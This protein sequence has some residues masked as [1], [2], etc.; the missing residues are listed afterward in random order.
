[1]ENEQ[2][3]SRNPKAELKNTTKKRW[4]KPLLV[5]IA[6]ILLVGGFFAW[7]TGSLFDKISTNGNLL[8]SLSRMVPGVTEELVGEKEGRVNILLLGMRG[9]ELTGGGLLA[10]T[11]MVASIAPTENKISLF[12]VPRDLYVQNPGTD[13]R[14]KINAVYAYGEEKRK[15]GGMEDMKTVVS[16]IVGQ[17]IGYALAINFKGFTDLVNAID[18]VEVDLK[19]PFEESMQFNEERACDAYTFTKPTGRFENKYYTRSEGTK[20]LAK[21]YPLC[22]NPNVE[23]GG[24]FKL[25]AGKQTLNG[26]QALCYARSR[27]TTSDFERAKRQQIVIQKIKDKALS[28]GTLTDYGRVTGMIDS[29]GNNV[30]TDMQAW[31]MKRLYELEKGM[32]NPQMAQRVLENST[33]G[34]LYTPEQRP[35]TGYILLPIGDNYDK[36]REVFKNIFIIPAQVDIEP[37]N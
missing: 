29:L 34:L 12:S 6:I 20:Y 11:I 27:K 7:K 28:L 37:K 22:T 2:V 23:C 35:E 25:P 5:I 30:R 15:G 14:S 17:P 9:E 33:E 8:G 31:E 16:E 18:G 21:S 4:L 36:I 1:M 26:E 19:Q 32:N 3:F 10:D 24:T 13:S